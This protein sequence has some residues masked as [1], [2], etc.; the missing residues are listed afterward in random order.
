M[1]CILKEKRA[2][3]KAISK[4][5]CILLLSSPLISNLNS[6]VSKKNPE[7]I[8][9]KSNVHNFAYAVK[10]INVLLK[11]ESNP[12]ATIRNG[13]ADDFRGKWSLKYHFQLRSNFHQ[14][15]AGIYLFFQNPTDIYLRS[16]NIHDILSNWHYISMNIGWH[17]HK[18]KIDILILISH[19]YIISFKLFIKPNFLFTWYDFILFLNNWSF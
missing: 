18:K 10:E 12:I 11:I 3:N 7:V 16:D 15:H 14:S 6:Y 1:H 19:S 17:M 2:A 8:K 9:S 5:F 4:T 13:V